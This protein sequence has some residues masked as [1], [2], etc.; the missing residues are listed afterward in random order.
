MI[1]NSVINEHGHR[2][3]LT[4]YDDFISVHIPRPHQ[5]DGEVDVYYG[6]KDGVWI[7]HHPA[8]DYNNG[9]WN[10]HVIFS[11][12]GQIYHSIKSKL[13]HKE[14]TLLTLTMN[15]FMVLTEPLTEDLYNKWIAEF[16][17]SSAQN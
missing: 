9:R 10:Q 2:A 4:I 7:R 13:T 5:L 17:R 14:F 8:R 6:F 3:R 1:Q 16:E 11:A 12:A 15:P